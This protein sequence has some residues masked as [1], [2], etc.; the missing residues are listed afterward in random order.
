MLNLF[1]TRTMIVPLTPRRT[2]FVCPKC[3]ENIN[4][5]PPDMVGYCDCGYCT[6]EGD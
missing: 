4:Y 2:E 5:Y 1:D 3:E 6:E